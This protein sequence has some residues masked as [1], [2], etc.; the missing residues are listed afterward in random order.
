MDPA[1][2]MGQIDAN[3]RA[4]DTAGAELGRAIKAMSEAEFAYDEAFESELLRIYHESKEAHERPPAEDV[5]KAMAHRAIRPTV[6]AAYLDAR[7][8]VDALKAYVR[9]LEAS[10]SARQSLLS[11]LKAEGGIPAQQPQWTSARAA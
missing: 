5:R 4:L 8:Q 3:A 11:A 9:A 2:L 10:V 7:A 6:Y 1:T